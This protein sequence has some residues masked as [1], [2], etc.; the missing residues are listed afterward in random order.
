[1]KRT[2]SLQNREPLCLLASDIVYYQPT[3]WGNTTVRQ[4]HMSLLKPRQQALGDPEGTFPLLVFLCGGAWM[5]VDRNVWTPE[6]TY[7]VKNG[8]AVASVE[9]SVLPYTAHP[10]QL[11]EVKRAIRFLRANAERFHIQKENI[12]I[13]GESA[14]AQLACMTALTGDDPQYKDDYDPE[15]SD[16]VNAAVSFYTGSDMDRMDNS[17][18]F[19]QW[20]KLPKLNN[21]ITERTPPFLLFHGTG[22]SMIPCEQSELFYEALQENGVESDLYLVE[23]ADHADIDFV[24]TPVKKIVLEF[25][26]AHRSVETESR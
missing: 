6:L 13:M 5:K 7:Y 2:L 23:N 24:Q 14:G 15:E 10:E 18:L 11:M 16:A 26:N 1:M 17:R 22:D 3:Y 25:L 20:Q 12:F 4:L 21:L 19:V 8:Y 9:Y